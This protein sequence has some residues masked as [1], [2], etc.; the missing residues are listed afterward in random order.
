MLAFKRT[1]S[2]KKIFWIFLLQVSFWGITGCESRD[3]TVN[4][5]S[6]NLSH[7]VLVLDTVEKRLKL[8]IGF[9][10]EGKLPSGPA[11]TRAFGW[12]FYGDSPVS[13][14]SIPK[15]DYQ[16]G[17]LIFCLPYDV[18]PGSYHLHLELHDIGSEKK[19]AEVDH[20]IKNIEILSA[21]EPGDG[22]NW[23]QPS[24]APLQNH[25]NEPLA[26]AVT[27]E[28][29]TRG[30]ILWHRN[31]F[32]YVYP[33]STPAQSEVVSEISVRLAQDEYEPATFSLYG[34]KE[35][36]VVH[37]F[38]SFLTNDSRDGPLTIETHIVKTVPR[39]LSR[40]APESGYEMR[41]RLLEKGDTVF[42][43][44]GNSQRFWLTIHAPDKTPPGEYSGTITITTGLGI[45]QVP[46]NVEVLPFML[47]ERPDKEYGFQMTYEFQEVSADDINE[48]QRQKIYQNGLKYYTS[49][50]THGL[51]TIIPHSPF[52]FKRLPDGSPDL[53]DL[54]YALKAFMEVGFSGPFIYYCGHLVQSSKPG[55]AGSTLGY[56]STHHPRLMKEIITYANQTIPEIHQV[57]FYWMPGDEVQHTP[58]GPDRMKIAE[59]L[60][61]VIRESEEKTAICVWSDVSWPVD[62]K[63][64]DPAPKK[65]KHWCY[66]NRQ[67]TVPEIVDDASGFRKYFGLASIHNPYV[68]I[69]PWTFQTTENAK[70]DPYTD[71]DVPGGPEVM[72]AY[73]GLDGPTPTIEYEALREG[74]DDGRYG[75]ILEKRID[76]AKHSTDPKIKKMGL[77]AEAAYLKIVRKTE[78]ATLQEMAT[79]REEIISWIL[80]VG[81]RMEK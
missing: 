10:V 81:D 22:T 3:I 65:G 35:L 42:I 26:V 62:I 25:P 13:K 74:I 73:P 19:V 71:V 11:G 75:Y 18:S 72:V 30:Y 8:I 69:A 21:R 37:I 14:Y 41:P 4:I 23:M 7:R 43:K 12:L 45:S 58:S 80:R 15:L 77:D 33:N 46:L 52:V 28:D 57:D 60:L 16:G 55:W 54:E 31:P 27:P 79:N 9:A 5:I 61:G 63:F 2:L 34:L 66:P 38:P 49:F 50:K 17:N 51:T 40:S 32:Q 39:K 53:R 44:Q 24:L 29:S 1:I 64:G 78:D 36:G 56:D 67:T 76:A 48:E 70:G 59:E 47:V 20:V 6:T 68:G